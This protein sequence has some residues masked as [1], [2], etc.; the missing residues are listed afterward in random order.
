MKLLKA[1][2]WVLMTF[3][4][5][6]LVTVFGC[7]ATVRKSP[8]DDAAIKG[9]DT[10][11]YFTDDKALKGNEY[12]AF[13]WH[14]MTWF[15]S[16]LKNKDLFTASPEKY[17]PQYDGYCA[18]ALTQSRK[19]ITDPEVWKI[20]KGKLYLNSSKTAHEKWSQDI[21]GNII[22]ANAIWLTFDDKY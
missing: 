13:Q 2:D 7:S 11:A 8:A 12:F 10:V 3:S 6:L 14:D 21:P 22:K 5:V 18:W 17:A 16:T 19:A 20:V 9:Y 1:A 15:F 4:F